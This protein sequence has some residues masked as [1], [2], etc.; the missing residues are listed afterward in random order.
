ML[1]CAGRK[2]YKLLER[3]FW[4]SVTINPPTYGADTPLSLFR[5]DCNGW[6]LTD[7]GDLLKEKDLPEIP[8]VTTPMTY[9]GMWKVL[10]S[11]STGKVHDSGVNAVRYLL[12]MHTARS[13][14][15]S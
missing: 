13:V 9:F 15:K 6:G 4:K 1:R 3:H 11:C 2:D 14:Y 10:S 12:Q 7:I 8:G 5:P